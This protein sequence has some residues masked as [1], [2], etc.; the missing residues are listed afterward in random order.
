M[1]KWILLY[2]LFCIFY[3]YLF[4]YRRKRK[5]VA[6][7]L[8]AFFFPLFG[9][10][11]IYLMNKKVNSKNDS[12]P[13]WL[14]KKEDIT[15]YKGASIFKGNIE[16]ERNV[17][18]IEDAL[19][20]NENKVKRTVLLDLLKEES[21]QNMD[22]LKFAL[23]NEDS[24]TSH[25][26]A[27]AIM[28]IKRKLLNSMQKLEL[29]MDDNPNDL[30]V[31]SVYSEV[32]KKYINSGYLDEKSLLKNR[33]A[34]SN[35]LEKMIEI[36]PNE[37]KYFI[38]KVTCDL[39]LLE[40]S[41]ARSYCDLFLNLHPNCEE[42]YF[43]DMH[44]HYLM[45]NMNAFEQALNRLRQSSVRLSPNGLSRLRFWLQGEMNEL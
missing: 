10:L 12:K 25:Y 26:A 22:A 2:Q 19:I 35:V 4:H 3:I 38:D 20:L 7:F 44:I 36:Q 6:Q 43:M 34:L 41:T 13:E 42:A 33:Y 9:F 18:P 1:V 5:W 23:K 30:Q 16:K 29:Q 31:L 27:T 14:M 37:E 21:I 11:L 24:E 32:V 17:I 45:K 40:Y 15:S 39:E 28:E 8:I